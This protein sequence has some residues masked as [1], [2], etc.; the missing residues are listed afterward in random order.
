[1]KVSVPYNS[2]TDTTILGVQEAMRRGH[3]RLLEYKQQKFE[4]LKKN[5][6]R[7]FLQKR[8]HM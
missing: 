8:S 4:I 6:A 7:S 1:M 2:M 5:N 3:F